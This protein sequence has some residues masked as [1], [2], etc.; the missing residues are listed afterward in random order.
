MLKKDDIKKDETYWFSLAYFKHSAG[1]LSKTHKLVKPI[2]V[3]VEFRNNDV[4]FTDVRNNQRVSHPQYYCFQSY[5]ENLENYFGNCIF[6]TEDEAW[7]NF[8]KQV[9]KEIERLDDICDKRRTTYM[10][11]L[12][13]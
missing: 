3:K 4:Y 9:K 2:K 12:I 6:L 11:F 5:N 8:Y 7:E 10:S 1:Q 13:K